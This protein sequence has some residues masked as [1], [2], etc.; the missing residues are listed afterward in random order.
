MAGMMQHSEAF[1]L[2][3]EVAVITGGG[4]GIGLG[5]ARCMAAA[6]AKVV[7]VGRRKEVLDA[8]VAEIGA[9]AYAEPQDVTKMDELP[10]MVRRVEERVGRPVSIVMNNAGIHLKK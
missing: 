5:I 7:L 10:G 1:R 4:T 6:G 8:A 9:G 3:G 2:D